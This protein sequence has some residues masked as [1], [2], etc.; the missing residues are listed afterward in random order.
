V[1]VVNGHTVGFYAR[2]ENLAHALEVDY[3]GCSADASFQYAHVVVRAS[4]VAIRNGSYEG[5]ANASKDVISVG[6]SSGV[7]GGDNVTV[8]RCTVKSGLRHGIT[9]LS[10]TNSR[11]SRNTCTGNAGGGIVASDGNAR[12][13]IDRNTCTGN[14][15]SNIIVD[16]RVGATTTIIDSSISVTGNLVESATANHG[17]Y[18]QY[19]KGVLVEA[20]Q[21]RSNNAGASSR[22]I[23]LVNCER[24]LVIGNLVTGNRTGIDCGNG[25]GAGTVPN[26][27][28]GNAV[29]GNVTANFADTGTVKSVFED[30]ETDDTG[31]VASANALVLPLAGLGGKQVFIVSGT[32]SIQSINLAG[33]TW[34]GREVKLIFSG[35]AAGVG[36]TD[37][38]N[39][40]LAGNFAYSVAAGGQ[41][42]MVLVYDGTNWNELDRSAN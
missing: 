22:G 17:I 6:L 35:T 27:V 12:L 14:G 11:A 21:V 24:C 9:F 7:P 30:N 25:A 36:M 34:D 41:D 15:N 8:E 26:Y 23:F 29:Y 1:R 5:N 31:A 13:S 37:G 33:D 19:A 3:D 10:A 2:S 42:T 16:V 38:S 4:E 20:N 28:R 18:V 32:A 39:L 40:N